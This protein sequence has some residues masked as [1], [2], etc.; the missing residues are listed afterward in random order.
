MFQAMSYK[1]AWWCIK[2][3]LRGLAGDKYRIYDFMSKL[4]ICMSWFAEI[5]KDFVGGM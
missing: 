1:Y 5:K 4:N 3:Y 2:P